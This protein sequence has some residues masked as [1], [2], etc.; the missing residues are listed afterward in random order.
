MFTTARRAASFSFFDTST[1]TVETIDPPQTGVYRNGFGISADGQRA[2]YV[3][4]DGTDYSPALGPGTAGTPKAYSYDRA[5]GTV[6]YL[7]IPLGG[8]NTD[9]NDTCDSSAISA[10]GTK[11][12]FVCLASDIVA[13]DGNGNADVFARTVASAPLPDLQARASIADASVSEPASGS[14]KAKLTITLDRPP[15]FGGELDVTFTDG[16]ATSPSDYKGTPQVV[17]IPAGHTSAVVKVP[18]KADHVTEGNETFSVA[19]T[20]A[21]GDVTLGSH[22][23]AVVTIHDTP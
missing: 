2:V 18:I 23:T 16:I 9:A 8:A 7:S 22:P 4:G 12:A 20:V 17:D 19:F 11:A 3:G 14:K 13:G 5:S 15:R 6:R 1:A 21:Y 10:D